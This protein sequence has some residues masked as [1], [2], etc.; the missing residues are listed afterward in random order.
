[1]KY[2]QMLVDAFEEGGIDA[3][4]DVRFPFMSDDDGDEDEDEDDD[5][6]L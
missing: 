5:G 3:A 2:G 4:E 1:M 6:V